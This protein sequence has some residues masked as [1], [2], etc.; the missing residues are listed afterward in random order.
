MNDQYQQSGNVQL[1]TIGVS[2][3]FNQKDMEDEP[4]ILDARIHE[5][6]EDEMVEEDNCGNFE[7]STERISV[8]ALRKKHPGVK[9]YPKGGYAKW[10]DAFR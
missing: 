3:R 1:K 4:T 10:I 6:G 9:I 5:Y 8:D 7:I 2:P